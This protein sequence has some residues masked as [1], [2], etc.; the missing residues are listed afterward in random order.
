M[1]NDLIKEYNNELYD[2]DPELTEI[3]DNFLTNQVLKHSILSDKERCIVTIASLIANESIELYT[4]MMDVFIEVLTPVEV[5]EIIYQ[6]IVYVGLAKVYSFINITNNYL[7]YNGIAL[8]LKGQKKIKYEDRQKKGYKIQV[9][10][11]GKEFIDGNIEACPESQQHI[12]DFI[13][14]FAFGDF[15]TRKG[16]TE[17]ERELISFSLILSLRGCE[18]Q[19]RIHTRGNLEVGNSKEKL[20]SVI[21]VLVLY[22]GFPRTH[23]A[24]AILN[25]V[26]EELDI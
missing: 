14:S 17:E 6:S 1:N 20:E 21:T 26:C 4:D 23:N 5:K 8:P 2:K 15:Y 11:F 18:N 13:S 19:L 24:L 3:I 9:K 7:E 12:W 10:N 22:N 25:E 16:L